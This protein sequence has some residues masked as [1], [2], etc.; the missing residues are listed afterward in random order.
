M[1]RIALSAAAV[2]ALLVFD[3]PS[4]HAQVY[5]G[6]APWCAVTDMGFGDIQ[7]D[8]EYYSVAECVPHVLG[9]NRGF[10]NENPYWKGPLPR[11]ERRGYRWRRR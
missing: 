5:Y 9:G 11:V 8:C 10:C 2:A 3:A 7:W 4:G 1:M 6:N